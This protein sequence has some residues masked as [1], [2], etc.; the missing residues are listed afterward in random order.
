L[1]SKIDALI[2]CGHIITCIEVTG[3]IKG[4]PEIEEWLKNHGIISQ[5]PTDEVMQLA[6]KMLKK[7]PRLIRPGTTQT[8]LTLF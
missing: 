6:E 2:N 1:W 3:E 4:D 8:Q 7:H 5:K